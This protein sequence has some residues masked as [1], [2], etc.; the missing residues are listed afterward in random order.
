ML[1]MKYYHIVNRLRPKAE[2]PCGVTT[3]GVR[4]YLAAITKTVKLLV[5]LER[6]LSLLA[7]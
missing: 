6:V 2:G 3:S 1:K 5:L 7:S 4:L